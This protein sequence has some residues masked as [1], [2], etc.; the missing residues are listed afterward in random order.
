MKTSLRSSFFALELALGVFFLSLSCFLASGDFS[1]LPSGGDREIG[2]MTF[3]A[4][5]FWRCKLDDLFV[6]DFGWLVSTLDRTFLK[7]DWLRGFWAWFGFGLAQ[8]WRSKQV[9]NER[10][11]IR[12]RS[13]SIPIDNFST[14]SDFGS[15]KFYVSPTKISPVGRHPLLSQWYRCRSG[16]CRPYQL[17]KNSSIFG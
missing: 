14:G 5:F 15:S 4:S 17:M 12:S 6:K 3:F 7:A 13:F 8:N 16:T 2:T 9:N 10:S 11:L 1:F